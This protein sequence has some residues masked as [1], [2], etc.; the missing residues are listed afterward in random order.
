VY[1][2][3]H[4]VCVR[5]VLRLRE[6]SSLRTRLAVAAGALA[7]LAVAFGATTA[8][9][10]ESSGVAVLRTQQSAGD[11][12]RET[13]VWWAGDPDGALWLEAATPERAF[14]ADV[15]ANAVVVL[16][17]DGGDAPF[18]ADIVDTRDAHDHVRALLRAKYGWR[19]AWVALLQDTSRSVAVRLTPPTP[20][21][22]LRTPEAENPL[23]Q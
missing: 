9:V 17:R 7:L 3:E 18:H 5:A 12:P 15:R 19:D 4:R 1:Q 23:G 14:L 13:H 8:W 2:H 10:L 16:A 20:A 6:V 11:E 22:Q 21:I